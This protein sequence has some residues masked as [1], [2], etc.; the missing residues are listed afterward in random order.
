MRV[1]PWAVAVAH[2]LGIDDRWRPLIS[3]IGPCRLRRQPDRFGIL[4]RAIVGQ[5]I[6]S[7]A[8]TSINRRLLDLQGADRHDAGALLRLGPEGVRS[9]GLSGVKAG[10]V[11]NL[12]EAVASGS[13]TLNRIGRLDDAEIIRRLT[14]IKGI[15]SWTAEMFLIFALNRPDVLS[16]GDLGVRVGI[17]SHFGLDEMPSP[18]RCVELAEPWRPFRSIAMWYFWRGIDT[19][20]VPPPALE[21]GTDA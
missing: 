10:Y 19:P 1:D 4:V 9:C 16:V 12:S 13:I 21:P 8:A 14:A 11:L 6:S 15:G 7:R 17:R 20:P 2:L 5:Q 18:R 3:R